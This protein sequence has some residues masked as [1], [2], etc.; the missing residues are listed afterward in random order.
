MSNDQAKSVY[1][2]LRDVLILKVITGSGGRMRV[3]ERQH[4]HSEEHS[5]RLSA[6][7]RLWPETDPAHDSTIPE[8]R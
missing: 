7:E 5:A 3:P 4:Q 2:E 8:H 1:D 6:M